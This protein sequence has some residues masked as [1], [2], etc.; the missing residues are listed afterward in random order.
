M[1]V[2]VQAVKCHVLGSAWTVSSTVSAGALS[3]KLND[4]HLL[5]WCKSLSA[6]QPQPFPRLRSWIIFLMAGNYSKHSDRIKA[7]TIHCL[8]TP[9]DDWTNYAESHKNER[10]IMDPVAKPFPAC[11][12]TYS[13][14]LQ[15]T[16][17]V[18]L[19][20]EKLTT[21]RHMPSHGEIPLSVW[22]GLMLNYHKISTLLKQV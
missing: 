5:Y 17:N 4:L 7:P 21:R 9:A 6:Q 16:N 20:L 18:C 13:V 2:L 10:G 11:Q 22:L 1:E 8:W 15:I 19:A 3:S 12:D 14:L